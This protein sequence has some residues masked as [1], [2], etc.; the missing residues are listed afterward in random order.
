METRSKASRSQVKLHS[1]DNG[2][3]EYLCDTT[4]FSNCAISEKKLE[5]NLK[6]G[7]LILRNPRSCWEL[8]RIENPDPFWLQSIDRQKGRPR[9]FL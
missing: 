9:I 8:K 3:L 6:E 2:R 7:Q 1:E 4:F 5:L